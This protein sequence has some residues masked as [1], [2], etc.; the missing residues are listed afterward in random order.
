MEIKKQTPLLH[1]E[2]NQSKQMGLNK[3]NG[4]DEKDNFFMKLS[5][6]LNFRGGFNQAG[7]TKL[8]KQMTIV[9]AIVES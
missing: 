5:H 9:G 8:P 7:S 3:T 4:H 2:M 6:N 1:L